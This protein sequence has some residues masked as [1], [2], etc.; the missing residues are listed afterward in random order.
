[1]AAPASPPSKRAREAPEAA[2]WGTNPPIWMPPEILDM[3]F[4][5]LPPPAVRV[6]VL[7]CRG[8]YLALR[9]ALAEEYDKDCVL[10]YFAEC[11]SLHGCDWAI[12]VLGATKLRWMLDGAAQGGHL[13]LAKTAITRGANVRP[14]VLVNATYG[15]DWPTFKFL[16]MLLG[17]RASD[18][19]ISCAA[20]GGNEKIIFK[21][22]TGSYSRERAN[23][24][25]FRT[26]LQWDKL[27]LARILS[28]MYCHRE[29]THR[30]GMDCLR[31]YRSYHDS[32][33]AAAGSS[34]FF[35]VDELATQWANEHTEECAKC[36][37]RLRKS[38]V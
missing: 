11:G 35:D 19:A 27:Y 13:E 2:V 24:L 36:Q 37:A 17:R 5:Y 29:S 25:V 4:D 10:Q 38:R 16:Y 26:A 6:G 20:V 15:G 12:R 31:T 1:M 30:I 14:D 21:L 9:E 34:P 23:W 8:W 7:V 18:H 22:I 33:A 28:Q 3:V 32:H